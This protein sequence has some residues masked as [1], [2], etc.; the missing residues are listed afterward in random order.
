V[1]VNKRKSKPPSAILAIAIEISITF[2][3]SGSSISG[4]SLGGA[5][6]SGIPSLCTPIST[7]V[8]CINHNKATY[9]IMS[10][11]TSGE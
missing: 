2:V 10:S 3:S 11:F 5:P 4:S 1:C 6:E 7:L 9:F 8:I